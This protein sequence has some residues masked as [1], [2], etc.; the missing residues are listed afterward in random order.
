MSRL[1]IKTRCC[2]RATHNSPRD[3]ANFLSKN[4]TT[5]NKVFLT[6]FTKMT[7]DLKKPKKYNLRKI[8]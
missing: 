8:K 5:P 4:I 6:I 2:P 7:T 3:R 1:E